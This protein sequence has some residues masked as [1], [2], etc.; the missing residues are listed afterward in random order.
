VSEKLGLEYLKNHGIPLNVAKKFGVRELRYPS[1]ALSKMSEHWGAER[2]FRCGLAWGERGIPER[3]IWTSY[4]ILFP[5]QQNAG[6]EYIQGR[7]FKG[8]PK[9]LGP[10]GITKPLYNV[11]RTGSLSA[12]SIIHICE[13]I[14]DALALEAQG[15]SAVAVLGASSF[16][17]EW[18]DF[19]MRYDVVLIPDRDHGGDTF[20][21]S[22]SKYFNERGK[23]V[24]RVR[25]PEGKKDV[26]DVIAELGRKL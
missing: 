3:L 2:V 16:R 1:R 26:A 22:I 12:G 6:I 8:D 23:T 5:F 4:A 19:F 11:E 13:G 24:R 9:Y 20:Y 14:P 25:I 7:L 10:R 18:T 15:L 17:A 21:K